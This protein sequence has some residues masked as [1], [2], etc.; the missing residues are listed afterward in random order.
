MR[1]TVRE[2]GEV[3]V[4]VPIWFKNDVV[5]AFVQKHAAWVHRALEKIR[6]RPPSIALPTGRADYVKQKETALRLVA[7]E[8]ERCNKVY[9]F[10]YKR[11][12]VRNQ[13]TC[14]G[15][16][17]A[18]GNLSFNYRLIYLPLELREYVVVHELCH[19]AVFGHGRD[20]WEQVGKA[21]P[22]WRERRKM[23]RRYRLR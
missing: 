17:S 2:G 14:W 23:M 1:L 11:I 9:G 6:R 19:L 4:S 8:V 7:S 3:V 10:V 12:S 22:D 5:H 13:K 18:K 20:F 16:C 21:V 15:S